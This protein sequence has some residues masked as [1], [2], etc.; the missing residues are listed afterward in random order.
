MWLVVI[1][2]AESDSDSTLHAELQAQPG[3]GGSYDWTW[4]SSPRQAGVIFVVRI[5]H[6][7]P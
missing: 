2:A 6:L 7:H 5:V 3:F 1:V 4:H